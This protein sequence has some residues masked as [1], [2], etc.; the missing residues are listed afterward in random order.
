MTSQTEAAQARAADPY[1]KMWHGAIEL[2]EL[3]YKAGALSAP[4]GSVLEVEVEAYRWR[5]YA[6]ALFGR[7]LELEEM[8]RAKR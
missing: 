8:L 5:S 6:L 7:C 2:A 4:D 1:F 3:M